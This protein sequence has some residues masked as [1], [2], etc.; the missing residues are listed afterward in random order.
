[1]PAKNGDP[2]Y[3][4]LVHEDL[5]ARHDSG[6]AKFLQTAVLERSNSAVVDDFARTLKA[7]TKLR[8]A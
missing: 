3:A 1:M 5:Q 4:I 2:D 7:K 6:Q 8:N